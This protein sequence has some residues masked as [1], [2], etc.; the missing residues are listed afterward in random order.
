MALYYNLTR[1]LEISDYNDTILNKRVAE[2]AAVLEKKLHKLEKAVDKKRYE[3]VL[4]H[5][6]VLDPVIDLLELENLKDLNHALIRWAEKNG[7]RTEGETIFLAHKKQLLLT[8][9]ELK[10]DFKLM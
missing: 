9:K 8:I 7:N 4:K 5:S 3:K 2:T 10:R 6:F 1:L